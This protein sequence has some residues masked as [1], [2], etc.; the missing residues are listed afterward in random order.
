MTWKPLKGEERARKLEELKRE[1]PEQADLLDKWE[2][3]EG[4]PA[5]PMT[6]K[7]F[8]DILRKR[9]KRQVK[10]EDWASL[11]NPACRDILESNIS[12]TEKITRLVDMW[13][14]ENPDFELDDV[15]LWH[16]SYIALHRE[17]NPWLF[18]QCDNEAEYVGLWALLLAAAKEWFPDKGATKAGRSFCYCIEAADC[19]S[20][21]GWEPIQPVLQDYLNWHYGNK[22]SFDQDPI[23]M[24]GF[25]NNGHQETTMLTEKDAA[26]A[27]AKAWNRLDCSEFIQLLAEDAVYESQWVFTPLEGKEDIADYLTGKM[28]TIHASGKRVRAELS[29][30]RCGNEYGKACVVLQQ[31]ENRDTDSVMVFEVDGDRIRRCDLCAP[32]FFNPEP[33]GIYPI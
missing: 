22:D 23:S 21:N 18:A 19:I 2:R 25:P 27:F 30:A 9:R 8:Q 15:D 26:L 11:A 28:E 33:T 20:W 10:V 14:K 32:E 31:C 29:T 1:F 17:M 7:E 24:T 12:P 13:L 6:A 3:E 4:P 16:P 5:P